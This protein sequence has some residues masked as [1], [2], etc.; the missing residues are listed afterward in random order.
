LQGLRPVSRKR[1]FVARKL[2]SDSGRFS[3]DFFGDLGDEDRDAGQ[4]HRG[5]GRSDLARNLHAYHRTGDTT[6]FRA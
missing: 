6:I 1:L 2:V 3:G 5:A 4:A